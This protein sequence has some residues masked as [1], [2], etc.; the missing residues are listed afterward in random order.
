MQCLAIFLQ[1]SPRAV[2]IVDKI[3]EAI[4]QTGVRIN[5][6]RDTSSMPVQPILREQNAGAT[7]AK[8]LAEQR[9][10]LSSWVHAEASKRGE[11]VILF[12]KELEPSIAL[13]KLVQEIVDKG[14]H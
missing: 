6:G 14:V 9:P 5:P 12:R 7:L 3:R 8:D 13:A 1:A 4:V 2:D 10:I 11:G